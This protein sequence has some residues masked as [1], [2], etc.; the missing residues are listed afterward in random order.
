MR[1]NAFGNAVLFG[2]LIVMSAFR[3]FRGNVITPPWAHGVN[4][5]TFKCK[6]YECTKSFST[7]YDE[8]EYIIDL[9]NNE[10]IKSSLLFGSVLGVKRHHA[11]IMKHLE[12]DVDI[13]VFETN[14]SLIMEVLNNGGVANFH[15]TNFGYHIY[16]RYHY[17]IDLFLFARSNVSNVKCI[18]I[19]GRCSLWYRRHHKREP[20][21]FPVSWFFPTV[22]AP[23]GTHMVPIPCESD[24]FLN[25]V[26]GD[27]WRKKCMGQDLSSVPCTTLHRRFPFV[28]IS[29]K[30][31]NSGWTETLKIGDKVIHTYSVEPLQSFQ[32]PHDSCA[33]VTY[34]KM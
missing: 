5:T 7:V 28:F 30:G 32:R 25:K 22:L 1:V 19:N 24:L 13:A 10:K 8:V 23:F 16:T 15:E 18:G 6:G 34:T 14:T 20:D 17:Y 12:K 29:R 11:A 4:V 3:Y 9:F 26:Y 27:T 21:I 2:I 33:P 31:S